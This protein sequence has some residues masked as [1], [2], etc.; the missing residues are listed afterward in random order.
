MS[1]R[2]E[3]E[4]ARAVLAEREECARLMCILCRH[5]IPLHG[6]Y[7]VI[8]EITEPERT[9]EAGLVVP[10]KTHKLE[11]PTAMECHGKPIRDRGKQ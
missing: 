2:C 4:V 5:G 8:S 9:E 10:A 7:H 11:P 6:D 1:K 3:G